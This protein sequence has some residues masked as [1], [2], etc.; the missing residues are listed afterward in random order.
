MLRKNYRFLSAFL[1]LITLS[2]SVQAASYFTGN[3]TSSQEVPPNSSTATGFGRVTLNDEENMITVS[4]YYSGLSSGLTLGHIHGPA[5]P[6]TNG[7]VIFNLNPTTGVTSGQVV[8]LT[9]GI[10]PSQVADLKAGLY[11]FNIHTGNN[12]GGEIRGQI[13]V[14][15]PYPASL[16]K[17][18][19]VPPVVTVSNPS[20]FGVVSVNPA[21]NQA[22]V[23]VNWTGLTA[24]V[25]AGHIHAGRS[26]TSGPIVCNLNP[27]A[28]ATGEAV[29]VLCNFTP[30]QMTA[31]RQAQFYINLHTA[32]F[33][34]GEIR[35]Q[36]QRRRA[37]TVDF[38]GDSKTDFAIARQNATA[39]TTEWWIS[40]SGGGTSIFPF[41]LNTDFNTQ[42]LLAGDFDGD[43]KDD[44]TIW[45]SGATP[46]AFFFILQSATLTVRAEQFGTTSDDARVIYDYDGDGR[47]DPA[48]FRSSTDTW[49]YLGS[50]NNPNKD[51]TYV[52]WGALFANPGDY[53]GDGKGDFLDQQGG[54][55]WLLSS[56]DASVK[57]YQLGSGSMFGNPGDFDGDGKTD[58]A[59][60]ISE[61][62]NLVWYSLSSLNPTQS[63]YVLRRAWGPSAGTRTRAQGD[64]DGDGR[65]E[66]AV[67]VE[68]AS[69]ADPTG[70]WVNDWAT[71]GGYFVRW[72]QFTTGTNDFPIAGFNNR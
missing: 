62:P 13:T 30:E 24:P 43:G 56:R 44:P 4:V 65:S 33:P 59:G 38:D 51:I 67:W 63:P 41:G 68:G 39:G 17:N 19:E 31:L 32:N 11:Y 69:A 45:R 48:V 71:G 2:V 54:L 70:F 66:Y 23:S 14:D 47:C 26:G 10:L 57:I 18:Q 22:L 27:P 25:M 21:T 61:T 42:R 28:Q 58:V 37:T 46:N 12:P 64:Y 5:A 40:N 1:W 20:G 8:G 3:L 55:W 72:G 52:R 50:A 15:A 29:D 9:F 35:G 60:S 6:G 34:N 53:D 49:Y 36:I 7:P 16:D